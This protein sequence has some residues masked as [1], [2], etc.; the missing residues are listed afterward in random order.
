MK[1][2]RK[3]PV[4]TNARKNNGKLQRRKKKSRGV[5]TSTNIPKRK[6]FGECGEGGLRPRGQKRMYKNRERDAKKSRKVRG[7]VSE[8]VN[9]DF[10]I[11]AP[12]KTTAE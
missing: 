9:T 2:E 12:L 4:L 11:N 1:G 5:K 6:H 8:K 3:S 10:L 7:S